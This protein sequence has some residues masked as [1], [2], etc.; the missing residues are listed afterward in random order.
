[1]WLLSL[2]VVAVFIVVTVTVVTV[3]VIVMLIQNYCH[4]TDGADIFIMRTDSKKVKKENI[5][6]LG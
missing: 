2:L 3:T 5:I 4:V 1:M 6:R